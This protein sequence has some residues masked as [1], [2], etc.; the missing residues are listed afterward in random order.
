MIL[1]SFKRLFSNTAK[2]LLCGGF[3]AGGVGSAIAQTTADP[4]V[5]IDQI[6]HTLDFLIEH[7]PFTQI[8]CIHGHY[9]VVNRVGI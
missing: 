2:L 3:F 7:L 6:G 8:L 5:S 1:S 4:N 9:A